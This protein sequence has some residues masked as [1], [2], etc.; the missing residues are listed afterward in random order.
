MRL[1]RRWIGFVLDRVNAASGEIPD[2]V[3]RPDDHP[4]VT[5]LLD[6]DEFHRA[7]AALATDLGSD[8][9]QVRGEAAEHIR[10][11]SATHDPVVVDVWHRIAAWL[12]RGYEIVADTAALDQLRQLD[13]QKTLIFL[14]SHRSYLDEFALPPRLAQAG[15]SPCFGMAGANLD[16]FP[17]GTLARRNGIVHVRRASSDAPV[18]RMALRLVVGHLVRQGNNLV[19]S[20][21][22]GR[23]RTGK[24]RPPRFGLL[25]YVTDAVTGSDALIVP[26]SIMYD[27]LPLHEV[28]LM[29]REAHGVSKTPED[30]KWM[31]AYARRLKARLGHIYLDFGAPIPLHDRMC[32]LRAEGLTD[33]QVVERLALDICHRINRT[34]P[35]TATAAVCVALLGHDRSLTLDQV[36]AT[37]EPLAD[38]LR[39]RGWA[40]AGDAD[41]TSRTTVSRTL[42]SLVDSGVLKCYTRGPQTVWGIDTDQHLIAAVYRN[43]AIHV[44]VVRAIAEIALAALA[45]SPRGD[46]RTAW[47]TALAVRE[48][49]KFDFFFA[50][51][52]EFA[53]ELW[54][55]VGLMAGASQEPTDR[56]D[57]AQ[58]QQ[59]LAGSNLIVAHLVLRPYV[60]AYRVVAQQ[61]LNE[62][63]DQRFDEQRF[64]DGCLRLAKQWSLQK[65]I[66]SE[67][68]ISREMFATGIKLAA[69]RGLI[70]EPSAESAASNDRHQL[71]SELDLL[72]HAIGMLADKADATSYALHAK[73]IETLHNPAM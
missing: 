63:S 38:Y 46:T 73:P 52:D 9:Q 51:R 50:G 33:R 57:A 42:R 7:T 6:S 8:Q 20:I 21:E 41:L 45:N 40:V 54:N 3:P 30:L 15:L 22:G 72:N 44:L 34:T 32:A 26:V 12:V 66:A 25:R 48:L 10:K 58:A 11:M 71:V 64:L 1:T 70:K 28:E 53:Q 29:A 60:D 5:T 49:M 47:H 55:E 23:T 68:S 17:L 31:A 2:G 35:V 61:L 39:A 37:V 18:Y 14:T 24:L 36:C 62:P 16:F 13:G 65:R 59:W 19:W 4:T 69:H 67:E 43:S 27:Q 56:L